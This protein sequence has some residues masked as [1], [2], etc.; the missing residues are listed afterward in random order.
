MSM[1]DWVDY[2]ETCSCGEV[3]EGFQSKD[4]E[5]QMVTY[6]PWNVR[7]FYSNCDKCDKWVEYR[8]KGKKVGKADEEFLE[9]SACFKPPSDWL[10]YYEK[11][12]R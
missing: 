9:L 4:G 5:C 12:D 3:I 8:F 2:E 7:S 10:T 1:F 11:S 6:K